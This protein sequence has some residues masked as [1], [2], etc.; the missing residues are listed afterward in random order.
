ME[1]KLNFNDVLS[2]ITN[3]VV[4]NFELSDLLHNIVKMVMRLL[5]AEVCSIFLDDKQTDS[6]TITMR[7]GS[8]FAESLVGKAQYKTGE[9]LTG[10]IYQSG[11]KFNIESPEELK[12]L[13]REN[14][15]ESIWVG[16]HDSEQWK[17]MGCYNFRNLIGLPLKIKD[18]IFGVIKVENKKGSH[19]AFNKDDENTFEIIANVVSLAIENARLYEKV[20]KQLKSISTKAAHRIN[21]KATDYD[22]IEYELGIELG[23]GICNHD[24]IAA[25][26]KRIRETTVSLKS[27]IGEF[28][29]FGKPLEIK[30]SYYKLN[31]I[32]EDEVWYAQKNL[33]TILIEKELDEYLPELYIDGARFAE[34]IK[35]MMRNSVKAINNSDRKNNGTIKI[36]TEFDTINGIVTFKIEDNGTGFPKDFPAFEAFSSTDPEGTGLGLC[37]VR[38]LVERHGGK[39]CNYNLEGGHGA[40][41]KFVLKAKDGVL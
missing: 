30:R 2:E 31:K 19:M 8:G 11:K 7:A 4:G 25:I 27:M 32:I 36:I 29:Q 26:K 24:N 23:K 13:K 39:I 1:K 28:T 9:G 16:K 37:T 17:D 40:G 41:I 15:N 34:A 21:N 22:A 12:K 3:D 6:D 35:E 33:D 18:E 10:F 20:E 5:D 38:E 14:T